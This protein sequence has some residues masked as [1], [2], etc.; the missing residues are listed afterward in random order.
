M[1]CIALVERGIAGGLRLAFFLFGLFL[2]L[3]GLDLRVVLL[4]LLSR[5]V[6]LVRSP[7]IN[8]WDKA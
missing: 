1:L 5:R 6:D 2:P 3:Q 4:Q 7:V 8:G